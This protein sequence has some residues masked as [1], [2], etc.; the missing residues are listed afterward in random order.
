[1]SEKQILAIRAAAEQAGLLPNTL[2]AWLQAL[3]RYTEIITTPGQDRPYPAPVLRLW[4]HTRNFVEHNEL[5]CADS[6]YQR[7][8][9]VEQH[10][11]FVAAACSIAGYLPSEDD[12]A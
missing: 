11:G 10:A 9:V 4:E 6:V 8:S 7:D 1:M 5:H 12:E 3:M 2:D